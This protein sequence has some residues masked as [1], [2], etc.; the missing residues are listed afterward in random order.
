MLKRLYLSHFKNGLYDL[1]LW[2][3]NS[4]LNCCHRGLYSR[5]EEGILGL[6]VG[7][8][9]T[10]SCP[11][12]CDSMDCHVFSSWPRQAGCRGWNS[13]AVD[14]VKSSEGCVWTVSMSLRCASLC[15]DLGNF[16]LLS[17]GRKEELEGRVLNSVFLYGNVS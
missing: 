14:K 10:K 2:L 6:V 15:F 3:I 17:W 7:C 5:Y 16:L 8:S 4:T 12:L 1:S 13:L 11:T 9:V